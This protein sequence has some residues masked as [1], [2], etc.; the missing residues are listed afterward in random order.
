[1]RRVWAD[2]DVRIGGGRCVRQTF[3]GLGELSLVD[4]VVGEGSAVGGIDKRKKNETVVG[5]RRGKAMNVLVGVVLPFLAAVGSGSSVC[6]WDLVEECQGHDERRYLLHKTL[7]AIYSSP[8][9]C[10]RASD[11]RVEFSRFEILDLCLAE[12]ISRVRLG[13]AVNL[14]SF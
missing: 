2:N 5:E 7:R 10:A 8:G 13:C 3:N 11:R 14:S 4:G 6:G 12:V 9:S 1:L